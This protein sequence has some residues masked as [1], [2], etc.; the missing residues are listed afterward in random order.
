MAPGCHMPTERCEIDH[1]VAWEIGGHTCLGNL[2]PLCTGHHTIKHHGGWRVEHIPG[3]ALRW[4]SPSGREYV[5][6]PERRLPVFT[7]ATASSPAP[8]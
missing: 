4:T 7:T 1:T 3:G 8:F 6:E 5:V 2:C